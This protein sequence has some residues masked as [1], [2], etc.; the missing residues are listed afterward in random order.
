[1][2]NAP[3]GAGWT[4]TAV[5][6]S[7]L[8]YVTYEP[9]TDQTNASGN[10]AWYDPLSTNGSWK[11][12]NDI[13]FIGA[14]MPNFPKPDGTFYRVDIGIAFQR[15]TQHL[16]WNGTKAGFTG[17][18]YPAP[19][20]W[21]LFTLRAYTD[22]KRHRLQIKSATLN[23]GS[24]AAFLM[25]WTSRIFEDIS[26]QSSCMPTRVVLDSFESHGISSGSSNFRGA[27]IGEDV[28]AFIVVSQ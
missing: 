24:P 22:G 20:L 9:T 23:S 26:V 27:L 18:P 19:A 13:F 14:D 4:P 16:V 2:D 25:W 10:A 3:S 15:D 12:F 6:S 28:D 17:S 1:K 21:G 5:H 8:T 11:V 7:A